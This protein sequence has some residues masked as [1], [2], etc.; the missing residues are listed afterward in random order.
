MLCSCIPG[1]CRVCMGQLVIIAEDDLLEL[2]VVGFVGVALSAAQ[3]VTVR[4]TAKTVTW[5]SVFMRNSFHDK[6]KRDSRTCRLRGLAE[7]TRKLPA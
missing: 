5:I 6:S 7:I 4:P 2:S 1:Q 3:A